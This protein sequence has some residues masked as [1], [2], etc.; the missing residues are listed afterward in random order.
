VGDIA[1]AALDLAVGADIRICAKGARWRETQWTK[2]NWRFPHAVRLG[3][4]EAMR[5]ALTG[6]RWATAQEA[7]DCGFVT[8]VVPR[9]RVLADG[10]RIAAVIASRGP[11]A[12]QLGKE[13]LWRG[14][15]LP[16]AAALRF[17]TDLTL[18]LQ[19]TKDR[20]EGVAAFMEKR[21]P[22]FTGE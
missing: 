9:A 11:I 14:L 19:T 13:A 20:S 4:S 2:R 6:Q 18:L 21:L 5:R 8:A 15:D 12:T 16:F 1:G 3:R 7:L 10:Q 17:E 22:E